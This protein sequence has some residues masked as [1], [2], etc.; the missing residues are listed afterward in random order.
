M[1]WS[2][3]NSINCSILLWCRIHSSI[4]LSTKSRQSCCWSSK[5]PRVGSSVPLSTGWNT[6]NRKSSIWWGGK[7]RLDG[8]V[9][10][11]RKELHHILQVWNWSHFRKCQVLVETISPSP[12]TQIRSALLLLPPN[13]FHSTLTAAVSVTGNTLAE[14]PQPHVLGWEMR[15]RWT[16]GGR[17]AEESSE[18]GLNIFIFRKKRSLVKV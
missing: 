12:D 14:T 10:V 11:F 1:S 4:H 16:E 17:G 6:T 9:S 3:N 8:W 5:Q 2:F 18:E 7:N 13:I 15:G